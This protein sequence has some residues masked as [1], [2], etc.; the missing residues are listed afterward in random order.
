MF[1]ASLCQV[2]GRGRVIGVDIEIRPANREAIERHPLADRI[3]LIEGDSAAAETVA[4]VQ[5][6]IRPGERVLVLLDSCHT[7]AHVRREL[8]A[9]QHL[10]SPGSYLVATDGIMK[11]LHDVPRGQPEWVED[12]PAAA[13]AE[14]A[15][16]HP[17]FVLE[18]PRWRFNESTLSRNVTWWPGAYLRRIN[19]A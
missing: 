1:Y 8:E 7:K 2:L 10:V 11:D 19:A 12:H 15:A 18:Q 16:A 13:A 9:Y 4:L 6:R 14:F 17:E 3:A 5:A